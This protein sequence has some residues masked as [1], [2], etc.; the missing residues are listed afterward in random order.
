MILRT[1]EM[2]PVVIY[3]LKI[4]SALLHM[5]LTMV[6]GEGLRVYFPSSSKLGFVV[7]PMAY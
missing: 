6:P 3:P 4:K 5:I 1:T 7:D 2:I